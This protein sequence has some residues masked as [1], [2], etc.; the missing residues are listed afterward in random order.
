[1]SMYL[2]NPVVRATESD[3]V[4]FLDL[5]PMGGQSDDENGTPVER[6]DERV[7]RLSARAR[8]DITRSAR[9]YI[10]E[11]VARHGGDGDDV[12]SIIH[13]L[14]DRISVMHRRAAR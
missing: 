4:E 2:P 11:L 6:P 1:M 9:G 14:A 5:P 12:Q 7:P 3:P 13:D 8:V 10:A